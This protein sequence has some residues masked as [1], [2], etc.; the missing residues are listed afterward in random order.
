MKALIW[1]GV[2]VGSTIGGY[3]PVLLGSSLFS[4]ASILGNGLGG[5]LGIIAGYKLGEYWGL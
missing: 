5:V 3:I 2:I 4:V 1:I